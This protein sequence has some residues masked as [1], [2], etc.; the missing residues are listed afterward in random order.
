MYSVLLH[1]I[2]A[3]FHSAAQPSCFAKPCR[4]REECIADQFGNNM[5][6]VQAKGSNVAGLPYKIDVSQKYWY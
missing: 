5:L 2:D 6:P 1:R 3:R 4:T